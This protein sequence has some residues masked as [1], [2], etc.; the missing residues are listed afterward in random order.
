[1]GGWGGLQRASRSGVEGSGT[2]SCRLAGATSPRQDAPDLGQGGALEAACPDRPGFGPRP[3]PRRGPWWRSRVRSAGSGPIVASSRSSTIRSGSWNTPAAGH[4]SPR[5][6]GVVAERG[7]SATTVAAAEPEQ[8]DQLLEGHAEG[9]VGGGSPGDGRPVAEAWADRGRVM[10][11]QASALRWSSAGGDVV[12]IEADARLTKFPSGYA[13]SSPV[14][15]PSWAWSRS[16][17]GT[18]GRL[19]RFGGVPGGLRSRTSG[20]GRSRSGPRFTGPRRGPRPPG[21]IHGGRREGHAAAS[22]GRDQPGRGPS[23][24]PEIPSFARARR[25][26]RAGSPGRTLLPADG[27]AAPGPLARVVAPRTP[28]RPGRVHGLAFGLP[29]PTS[30]AP[31]PDQ[32]E[33]GEG[34]WHEPRGC[35]AVVDGRSPFA[36]GGSS[37]RREAWSRLRQGRPADQRRRP[38]GP[39]RPST[40]WEKLIVI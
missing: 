18:A 15:V 22:G 27:A 34:A 35:P 9:W 38:L 28:G 12:T 31:P 8:L 32:N 25:R 30:T 40:L 26:R 36:A 24:R 16:R 33:V 19:A 6:R 10:G 1:M 3:R 37:V 4:S 7:W 14:R 29:R 21:A 39:A 20:G 17:P 2:A 13:S 5:V 11:R 23:T